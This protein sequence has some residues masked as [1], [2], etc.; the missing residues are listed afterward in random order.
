[1]VGLWR[2]EMWKGGQGWGEQDVALGL[3]Q[4]KYL[5]RIHL[6]LSKRQQL[7]C[8]RKHNCRMHLYFHNS[9]EVWDQGVL[10]RPLGHFMVATIGRDDR[11]WRREG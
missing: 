2:G 5:Q 4:R 3:A 8:G 10:K 1:M 6:L 7:A 11:T 9:A